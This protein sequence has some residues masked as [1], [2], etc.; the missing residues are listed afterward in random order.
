MSGYFVSVL[1]AQVPSSGLTALSDSEET[2]DSL[3][4][5][6]ESEAMRQGEV[7]IEE[8]AQQGTQAPVSNYSFIN[9]AENRI[10]MNGADWS[11]VCERFRNVRNE[12]FTFVHIGDS[13]LQADIATGLLRTELQKNFGNGGRGLIVP[14][15]LAGTNEPLDYKFTLNTSYKSAKIM[16]QPWETQVGFTGVGVEPSAHGFDLTIESLADTD[17]EF[18][19][20]RL[21]LDGSLTVADVKGLS[22]FGY[23]FDVDDNTDDGYI[24]IFLDRDVTNV[25]LSLYAP[26]KVTFFGTLL[27]TEKPGVCYHVIGNNGAAFSSYNSLPRFGE[28]ISTLYPDLIIVSLGTNDAFGR[29]DGAGFYNEID[30]IVRTMLTNNPE[31]KI[32]LTTPKECQKRVRTGGRRRSTSYRVVDNCKVVRDIIMDYGKEHGI[33]VY[34]W[35][36]VAGASGASDKWLAKDLLSKDRVHNTREGYEL[37]G[38]IFYDALTSA[39][40]MR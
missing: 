19:F 37:F 11:E 28:S 32:L 13:H 27:S 18:R 30:R 31:A 22:G 40:S 6:A 16:K 5:E 4:V 25:V 39:L 12:G 20:I 29:V 9:G 33:A 38:N 21:Y 36:T 26:S 2:A 3:F 1:Q 14:W 10:I 24:D 8:S 34:D 23:G 35:W 17:G 7:I 15:R